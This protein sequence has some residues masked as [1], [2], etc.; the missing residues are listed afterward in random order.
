MLLGEPQPRLDEFQIFDRTNVVTSKVVF[1]GF[2]SSE[3]LD[4]SVKPIVAEM[5]TPRPKAPAP[6]V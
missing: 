3:A 4:K 2:A 1:A 6:M 5:A